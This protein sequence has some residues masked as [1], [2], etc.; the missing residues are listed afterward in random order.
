MRHVGAFIH[1]AAGI[2]R[3]PKRA[4]YPAPVNSMSGL[5]RACELLGSGRPIAASDR[6]AGARQRARDAAQRP[7]ISAEEL[8]ISRSRAVIESLTLADEYLSVQGK[9][10]GP[11]SETALSARRY[12][13]LCHV[14]SGKTAF[15]L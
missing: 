7:R 13:R 5:K 10:R 12:V 8:A 2:G 14:L 3:G 11:D 6:L 4:S 1:S 9:L 15:R